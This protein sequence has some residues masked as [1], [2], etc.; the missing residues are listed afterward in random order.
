MSPAD[1]PR[2]MWGLSMNPDQFWTSQDGQILAVRPQG[3]DAPVHLTLAF[4]PRHP[5]EF[6]FA[7][8]QLA[9]LKFTERSTLARIGIEMLTRGTPTIEGQRIVLEAEAFIYDRSF[10]NASYWRKLLR[11]GTPI[12]RLFSAPAAAKLSTAEIWDAVHANQL[13]L[14]NTI[15]IDREGR[16]FLTPHQVSYTLNPRLPRESFERLVSGEAGRR[17]LDKAQIRHEA[18]PLTIPPRSGILTSC[19]MYLKEHFVVLNQGAGNFG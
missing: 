7:K 18:S 16:V 15:S 17:F 9:T 6:E 10:P 8:Q 5:A 14:P 19:S 11:L 3:E 1:S 12:G 4:W 13:K 2:S